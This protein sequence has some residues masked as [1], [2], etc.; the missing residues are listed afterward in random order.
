MLPARGG[1]CPPAPRPF[2][3]TAE[4][5]SPT[6]PLKKGD[7]EIVSDILWPRK[8]P[9]LIDARAR[10]SIHLSVGFVLRSSP[11]SVRV[12]CLEN[13]VCPQ[14]PHSAFDGKFHLASLLF[15]I[16]PLTLNLTSDLLDSPYLL[17]RRPPALGVRGGGGGGGEG[18]V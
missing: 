16:R 5:V 17:Y 15:L 14:T 12:Q 7:W 6:D 18:A 13:C 11:R 9:R 3:P 1:S 2:G 10:L 4:S 8:A